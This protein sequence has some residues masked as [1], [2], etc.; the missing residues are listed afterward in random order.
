MATK[1]AR[2]PDD[3]PQAPQSFDPNGPAADPPP[4]APPPPLTQA[5]KDADIPPLSKE[6]ALQLL[7]AG[8][9]LR[10]KGGDPAEWIAMT[11]HAG[12]LAI[13]F[14]ATE[15]AVDYEL[16]SSELILAE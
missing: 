14:P 13:S 8:H 12:E 11:R 16:S 3:D 7:K 4:D 6:E 15:S 2:T 10:V 5:E 1:K 9:R